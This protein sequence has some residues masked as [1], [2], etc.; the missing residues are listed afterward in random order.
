MRE[1]AAELES[2][3][4]ALSIDMLCIAAFSGYFAKLNPAWEKH[5]HTVQPRDLSE[6]LRAV[7][8]GRRSLKPT[9][10]IV[11]ADPSQPFGRARL[12]QLA[13]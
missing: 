7:A 4:F 10:S 13:Y 12:G 1:D 3:F 6:V 5:P 11:A 8:E 9:A 2:R